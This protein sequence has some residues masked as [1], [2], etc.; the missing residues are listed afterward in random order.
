VKTDRIPRRGR[1]A[2]ELAERV[3]CTPQTIRYW[4]SE[5]RE[6]YLSRAEQ[7]RE[8]IRELRQ[9]GMSMRAIAAEV[10]CSVGTVHGALKDAA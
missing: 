4:T 9:T 6:A 3:G 2:K 7:R 1:T 10:G 8:Q 5:P